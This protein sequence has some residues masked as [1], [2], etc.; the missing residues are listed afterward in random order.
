M[1]QSELIVIGSGK[2]QRFTG[3]EEGARSQCIGAR[4]V[5]TLRLRVGD[6]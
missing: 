4:L 2:L 3:L 5:K 6:V 1:R